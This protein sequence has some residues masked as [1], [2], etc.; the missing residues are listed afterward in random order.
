MKNV[1]IV[2]LAVALV[3]VGLFAYRQ[4]TT[5]RA[6]AQEPNATQVAHAA[7]DGLDLQAKCSKQAPETMRHFG[8]KAGDGILY[9]LKHTNHF[10]RQLN[11]CI[12]K[13]QI[14]DPVA[15]QEGRSHYFRLFVV[16]AFEF[17]T[18]GEYVELVDLGEP[19]GPFTGW[20]KTC[21]VTLPVGGVKICKSQPEF[22]QLISV[23]MER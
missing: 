14:S 10:N 3:I 12:V 2:L 5:V 23:Y 4:T 7:S 1:A 22:E 9:F 8:W 17:T 19:G 13:T 11:R 6:P 15:G 16:D 20:T 21:K 18:Y